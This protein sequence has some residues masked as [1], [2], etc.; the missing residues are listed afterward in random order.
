MSDSQFLKKIN[1][2]INSCK[3]SI[4]FNGR[5][6]T[7]SWKNCG[8]KELYQ[9]PRLETVT[10]GKRGEGPIMRGRGGGKWGRYGQSKESREGGKKR[11][12]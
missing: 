1:N 9:A 2:S 7:H 3:D 4:F 10:R 11:K 6:E 12:V 8:I 5:R